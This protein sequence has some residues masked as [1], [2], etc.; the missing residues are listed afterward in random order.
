MSYSPFGKLIRFIGSKA[1]YDAKKSSSSGSLI[2]AEITDHST[3]GGAKYYIYANDK[4]FAFNSYDEFKNVVGDD[5]HIDVT[6]S[7]DDAGNDKASISH[8]TTSVTAGDYGDVVSDVSFS[9]P[10]F[11]V[12]AAGHLTAANSI[13]VNITPASLGLSSAMH[14]VGA[15][16]NLPDI[17]D[18]ENG[19]VIIV[20]TTEGDKKY[21]KEYVAHKVIDKTGEVAEWVEYGDER[22]TTVSGSDFIEVTA[23]ASTSEHP[24]YV[25]TAKT[26][27]LGDAVGMT[28]DE[29]TG[30]W[31]SADGSVSDGLATAADVAAEIVADEQIIA[32]ALNDHEMRIRDLE[33]W[34]VIS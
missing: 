9:I 31:S 12:D 18:F 33:S 20:Y 29:S 32:A 11:T 14:F 26:I 13:D 7:K 2:F 24:D 6:Y 25:I 8:K 17:A 1:D 19:D 16:D 22:H 23:G 4:E 21:S 3:A 15:Y 28:Y 5:A 27:P 10:T 34:E 30:K